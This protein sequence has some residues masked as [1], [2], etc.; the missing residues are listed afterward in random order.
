MTS[1]KLVKGL[2]TAALEQAAN[3]FDSVSTE[4]IANTIESVVK[5]FEAVEVP[6]Q[7]VPTSSDFNDY[8]VKADLSTLETAL[9]AGRLVRPRVVVHAASS[10]IDRSILTNQLVEAFGPLLQGHEQRMHELRE[11]REARVAEKEALANFSLAML[12]VDFI[13]NAF[14]LSFLGL[15]ALISPLFWL[16]VAFGGVAV[17][18]ELPGLT[19][20]LLKRAVG[21]KVFDEPEDQE[22]DRLREELETYRPLLQKMVEK[23]EIVESE[24]LHDQHSK[25][26]LGA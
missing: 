24:K 1:G 23:A 19:W 22:I 17:L 26:A 25:F 4:A 20:K 5:R 16:L 11:E 18:S 10:A 9:N 3:A 6:V 13:L 14:M 8:R 21:L 7:C 15:G 12:S 2:G